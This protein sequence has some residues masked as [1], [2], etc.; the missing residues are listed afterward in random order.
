M[1]QCQRDLPKLAVES[2]LERLRAVDDHEVAAGQPG[3]SPVLT[4]EGSF[5]QRQIQVEDVPGAA[6]YLP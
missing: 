1:R 6:L 3:G 5:G 2:E 4:G